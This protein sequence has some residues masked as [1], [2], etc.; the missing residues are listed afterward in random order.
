M[1]DPTNGTILPPPAAQ[2]PLPGVTDTPAPPAGTAPQGAA[3]LGPPPAIP[4]MGMHSVAPPVEPSIAPEIEARI[5]A[6]LGLSDAKELDELRALR[7]R[8]EA[9]KPD[10]K[11]A[12]ERDEALKVAADERRQRQALAA[13]LETIQG[14]HRK[15]VEATNERAYSAWVSAYAVQLSDAMGVAKDGGGRDFVEKVLRSGFRAERDAKGA[16][17]IT[18]ADGDFAHARSGDGTGEWTQADIDAFA[19][20]FSAHVKARYPILFAAPAR[21]GAGTGMGGTRGAPPPAAPPSAYP[22]FNAT[23]SAI[24]ASLTIPRNGA[25][26]VG[27]PG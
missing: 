10:A 20:A 9:D 19:T 4:R 27:P 21:A 26:G 7:A 24:L 15:I 18:F 11:T 12:R 3:P 22:G 25:P 23:D 13:Q 17:K 8:V 5:L 14:E 1:T 2:P 6:R 16:T